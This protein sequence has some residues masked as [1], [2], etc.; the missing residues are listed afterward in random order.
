M[1]DA[2]LAG[3]TDPISFPVLDAIKF[4]FNTTTALEPRTLAEALKQPNA[5]RWIEAVLAE[6]KAHILNGTWELIQLPPGKQVISS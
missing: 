6:I 4:T 5:N 3:T 2:N 1:E